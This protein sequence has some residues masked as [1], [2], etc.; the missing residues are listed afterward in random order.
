[1]R[2]IML[3][4]LSGP[5]ICLSRNDPHEPDTD[6]EAI[7]LIDAGYAKA[8]DPEEEKAV[9]AA[10]ADGESEIP[11]LS[12]TI[13]PISIK[14]DSFR[15]V[16]AGEAQGTTVDASVLA[17]EAAA[18]EAAAASVNA[19]DAAESAKDATVGA[20]ANAEAAAP[21]APEP[22]APKA[23]KRTKKKA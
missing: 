7:R 19:T 3:T 16:T 5:T 20:D 21:K 13:S 14:A 17:D 10:L 6:A 11:V 2:L 23:A 12:A 22:P 4:G 1:M 15:V 18:A 8:E 9:R